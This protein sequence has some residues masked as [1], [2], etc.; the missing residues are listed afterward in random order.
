M[1]INE[2]G[3][4]KRQDKSQVKS[5]ES[6]PYINHEILSNAELIINI[7]RV[8]RL[9]YKLFDEKVWRYM[10][11]FHNFD[12]TRAVH[13]TMEDYF[14]YLK[15]NPSGPDPLKIRESIIKWNE[16]HP[17]Q[18]ITFDQL[19][20]AMTVAIQ[21][22]DLGNILGGIEESED[23]EE[24]DGRKFRYKFL[25]K[26]YA[27]KLPNLEGEQ[28]EETAEDRSIRI[29]KFLLQHRDLLQKEGATPIQPPPAYLEPLACHLIDETR[30]GFSEEKGGDQSPFAIAMRVFDQ[31]GNYIHNFYPI[32][33]IGLMIE[34]VLEY[35][36]KV[37]NPH[38]FV[39]FALDRLKELL[40]D[41]DSR[42]EFL[43]GYEI[44]FS[45]P[46][47]GHFGLHFEDEDLEIFDWFMQNLDQIE[48]IREISMTDLIRL[49]KR[50]RPDKFTKVDV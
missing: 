10:P 23:G 35:P 33:L 34:M 36:D 31:I 42:N 11:S 1:I 38:K 12:H 2:E 22:H 14:T 28:A 26:Y 17:T 48:N 13:R 4:E 3:R 7:A 46:N 37:F 24:I 21:C 29:T 8:S 39:N 27:G 15:D 47:Q 20:L 18:E 19:E 43:K 32:Y 49:L 16:D 40:P 44:D 45:L 9:A 6:T 30:Y 50:C 25:K 5:P 41:E